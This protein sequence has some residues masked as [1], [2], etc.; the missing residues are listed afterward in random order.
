VTRAVFLVAVFF[1]D[2]VLI[3]S[4]IVG[5]RSFVVEDFLSYSNRTTQ[6][7]T[8]EAKVQ[9]KRAGRAST[10]S[11]AVMRGSCGRCAG[12]RSWTGSSR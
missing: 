4:L 10:S 5:V 6:P 9:G 12:W 11:R 3:A 2:L 1:C 8:P 7:L